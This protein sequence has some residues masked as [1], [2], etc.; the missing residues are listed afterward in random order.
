MRKTI[1]ALLATCLISVSLYGQ[2]E[3]V[4]EPGAPGVIN[5][6]IEGDT[7]ATGERNDSSRIY[8][9]KRGFPYVLSGTVEFRD[10]HLSI[11]AEEGEGEK[12]F[13]IAASDGDALSQVFRTRGEA[14][15]TLDG[16]HISARDILG[17]FNLR[18][19]RI[20]S[21]NSNIVVNDCIIEDVGQAGIRVQGD[22]PSIYITNNVVRNMG[23]PFDPDNGRFIDNRGNPI[24]TLWLENNVIYNTSSRVYR[25]GGSASIDWARFNQNTIW[26]TG[27]QGMTLGQ[28][29][30]LEFT[31]NIYANGLF[32]G[33][34]QTNQDSL[35]IAGFWIMVDTFDAST[36]NYWISNNNFFTNQA[37]LDTFPMVNVNGDTLIS[38]ENFVFDPEIQAAID[39]SGTG[40]TNISEELAFANA[41]PLPFQFIVAA[42]TDTASSGI[43]TANFWDFSNL[44]TDA[45]LSA[46][47]TGTEVR[48]RDVHD[49]SY[50][51]GAVSSTGG[52]NGQALGALGSTT[53]QVIDYFVENQILYYPNPVTDRLYVQNLKSKDLQRIEI[54]NLMGQLV[55]SYKNIQ[56]GVF[57]INTNLLKSGTYVLSVVDQSGAISSRK[58]IKQ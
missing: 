40:E 18:L 30:S 39:S 43:P 49:F 29:N 12:P 44:T 54:Y 13:V 7:T 35:P 36:N 52:T 9:L 17:G 21:D 50:G 3:L 31:N 47:G 20:N 10:F 38:V 24:D 41:P 19:I 53:T 42:A 48:Y 51:E 26:G 8:V 32:L 55:N 45:D 6:T 22:N 11:K 5:S 57:E 23:R 25:N 46:L 58:F 33:R 37:I 14:S 2:T 34:T 28:I 1:Y 27:Q 4:I 16:L 15:L 56:S